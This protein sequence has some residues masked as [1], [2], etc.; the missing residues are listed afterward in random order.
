MK[1]RILLLLFAL[2]L[3][4]SCLA[5]CLHGPVTAG[6]A[7]TSEAGLAR[8]GYYTRAEDV[9]AYLQ[10]YKQLP[11]NFITK[12]AAMELGWVSHEGNLWEVTDRLSIGGDV[13]GNRE[14]LLPEAKGRRYFECDVNYQGGFRGPERLVYSND[15]LVFYTKD[16]YQ[17]FEQ[18]Y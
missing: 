16:H 5:G 9:A 18:L 13:F 3:L 2:F 15:G 10:Q 4:A 8:D 11:D 12:Q 6:P 14:G 7:G 1:S 17:T